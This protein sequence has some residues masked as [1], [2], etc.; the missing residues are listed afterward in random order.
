VNV[1]VRVGV[2]LNVGVIE[3]VLVGHGV[4]VPNGSEVLVENRL[5]SFATLE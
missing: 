2:L 1:R 4:S 5:P 3:A